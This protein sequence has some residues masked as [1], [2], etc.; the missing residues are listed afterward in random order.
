MVRKGLLVAVLFAVASP[1]AA[2]DEMVWSSARPDAQAP[3]GVVGGRTLEAGQF[4]LTYRF[5]K[6]NS[7]G[8]W[9][10]NYQ[11]S[12]DAT[13]DF[14]Q[15]VP[16]SLV[17]QTHT[18]GIAFAASPD[19]TVS[20][21]V[22]YS[23]RHREQLTADGQF[24]YTTEANKLTDLEIA[25]LYKVYDQGPYRAHLHLGALIPTGPTEVEAKTPFSTPGEEALPYDMRA[26]AGTFGATPGMT[27]LAQNEVATVGAQVTGTIFFGTNDKDWAP[28]TRVQLNAWASYRANE[29]FAVSARA[30]YQSWGAIDGADPA[31]SPLRDPGSDGLGLGGSRLDLPIG[32]SLLMPEGTRFAG[33]RLSL[34][35]ILPATHSYDGPQLG[36]DWGL[37]AGWQVVF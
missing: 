22:G 9:F 4:E 32:V 34:E 18:L 10:D 2:Q 25:G 3:F 19:L 20:A 1:V 5:D 36:S 12:P 23:L 6:R 26:G 16:L 37:V 33:H 15:V 7:A 35:Y 29:Y 17:N 8:V 14:Y 27:V 31:L 24:F 21:N 28:G 30:A 11:L 13:A